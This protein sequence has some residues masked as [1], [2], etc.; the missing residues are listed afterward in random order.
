M[1]RERTQADIE[2][3]L[4]H[5]YDLQARDAALAVVVEALKI[6]FPGPVCEVREE[7]TYRRQTRMGR[8][9]VMTKVRIGQVRFTLS[10]YYVR[11]C[12]PLIPRSE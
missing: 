10:T 11:P 8:D 5:E 9:I 6:A 12:V 1:E 2:L 4:Q 7:D 3:A